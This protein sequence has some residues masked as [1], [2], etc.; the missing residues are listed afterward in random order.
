MPKVSQQYLDER[1]E[2]I[3]A[4]A[5]R[6]FVRDGFHATSMQDLFAEA[7][8]SSGAVY[9]YFAS[10]DDVII[11]IAMDNVREVSELI[12]SIASGK[13]GASLG[14][15]LAEVVELVEAKNATD[16]FGSV[17]L[18]VWA[19]SMR[20][21]ALAEELSGLLA[22]TRTDLAEVVR[23]RQASGEL[24]AGPADSIATALLA[25]VPGYVLQLALFAKPD[26]GIGDALRALWPA[27][28][29]LRNVNKTK[30]KAKAKPKLTP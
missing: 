21:P 28:P 5:R 2:Q 8:L 15:A 24:P 7:G 11:A 22:Q 17:A 4:A 23:G 9:R 19:E 26:P 18:Q 13:V 14:E 30:T 3:L 10:K 6:C 29:K 12:R 27:R 25:L 1:R 16:A 20:N